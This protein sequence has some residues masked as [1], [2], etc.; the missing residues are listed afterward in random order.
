[1]VKEIILR[2]EQIHLRYLTIHD[3]NTT[4][5]SWLQDDETMAGLATSVY[6]IEKLTNYVSQKINDPTVYF[7]A[8]CA[9]NTNEHIGNIKLDFY[10]AKA[11]VIEL[12]ILI[13][14][15]NYWGKG[16]AYE[17]CKLAIQYGFN[18]LGLR[19]IY[20]SVYE[21]NPSAKRVYEKLGFVLEGTLRKHVAVNGS[22]YDKYYMGLF[23]EELK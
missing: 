18:Q 21:N 22:F 3:I 13:G 1:M 16:I 8:I 6:T 20:L 23:K 4:Y 10:D 5:L 14:N 19:K 7:F 17:S 11:N 2:G 15:K 12:G 9:N